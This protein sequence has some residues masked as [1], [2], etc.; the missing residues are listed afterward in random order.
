[1]AG[2]AADMAKGPR[3]GASSPFARRCRGQ[4]FAAGCALGMDAS[5]GDIWAKMKLRRW[6][7][8]GPLCRPAGWVCVWRKMGRFSVLDQRGLIGCA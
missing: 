1:M 5:G 7:A 6:L 2:A 8:E 4:A 3:A